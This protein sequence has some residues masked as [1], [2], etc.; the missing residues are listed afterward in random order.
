MALQ[1]MIE[2]LQSRIPCVIPHHTTPL[3]SSL[4]TQHCPSQDT[5]NMHTFTIPPDST[6][7]PTDILNAKSTI[8]KIMFS[9]GDI[10]VD[11]HL[12]PPVAGAELWRATVEWIPTQRTV[13]R[14]EQMATLCLTKGELGREIG[15]ID[16]GTCA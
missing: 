8:A 6:T 5:V 7:L 1:I 16:L 9:P 2:Y 10:F 4:P 12:L 14:E 11:A 13:P 15:R 3:S